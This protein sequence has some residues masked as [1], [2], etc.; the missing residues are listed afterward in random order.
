L[1]VRCRKRCAL[2]IEQNAKR[3]KDVRT[4]VARYERNHTTVVQQPIDRWER[5]TRGRAGAQHGGRKTGTHTFFI[6]IRGWETLAP[7]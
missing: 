1:F 2:C 5:A 4:P 3:L 6:A 7:T